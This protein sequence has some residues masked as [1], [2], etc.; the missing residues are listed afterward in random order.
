[1]TGGFPVAGA[2]FGDGFGT[3]EVSMAGFG[4][5]GFVNGLPTLV[6]A[7]STFA[8]EGDVTGGSDVSP[9]VAGDW[10]VSAVFVDTT[11]G[12]VGG[13]GLSGSAGRFG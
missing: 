3:D 11:S 1:L 10:G 12:D 2:G 8:M 13:D 6:F 5:C 9:T 4:T 7:G